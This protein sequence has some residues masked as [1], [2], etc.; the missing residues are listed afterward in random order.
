MYESEAE[1]TTAERYAVENVRQLKAILKGFLER[2]LCGVPNKEEMKFEENQVLELQKIV[3][4][5]LDLMFSFVLSLSR[6][7]TRPCCV[8]FISYGLVP[9]F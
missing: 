3:S 2:D 1:A 5:L 7:G 8:S 6:R 4:V 9:C